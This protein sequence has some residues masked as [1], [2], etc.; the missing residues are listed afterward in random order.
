MTQ[1][2]LEAF[3]Y[4]AALAIARQRKAQAQFDQAVSDYRR[5]AS[6]A[7][8][9]L[10]AWRE[11]GAMLH[12]AGR[13]QQA[14]TVLEAA[15]PISPEDYELNFILGNTLSAL[16]D[17]ANAER[18]YRSA[19]AAQPDSAIAHNNL[20]YMLRLRGDSD[21]A[22]ICFNEAIVL[23]P[24]LTLA[25]C[26]LA[27]LYLSLDRS[28]ETEKTARRAVAL[29][30]GSS[31]AHFLLARALADQNALA[32]ATRLFAEGHSR[33]PR[34]SRFAAHLAGTFYRVGEIE[35]ALWHYR[36]AQE[37][38]PTDAATR[39]N[40]LLM[41]NYRLLDPEA[42]FSEHREWATRIECGAATQQPPAPAI[43]RRPI[44][45]G[46][47]SA[48]LYN[49][50]VG[51]L[52][53]PVLTSHD[54]SEFIVHCYHNNNKTDELTQRLRATGLE[55]RNVAGMSDEALVDQVRADG[56]D[57][58]VDL[59]GHTGGNRLGVFARRAAPVQAT[60]L[61]Y[62]NTTGLSAMDYRITDA[63]AD[64]PGLSDRFHSEALVRLPGTFLCAAP[65]RSEVPVSPLPMS[66]SGHVT[67]GC[68]NNL[69]KLTPEV[70][71][72]WAQLIR[73]VERSVL[74]IKAAPL[75]DPVIRDRWVAQFTAHGV[76]PE[77]LKLT[78]RTGYASHLAA[79]N[80]VDLALDPFP[81]NG[82]A[83]SIEGLWMG[84]PF[85]TLAGDRHVARVGAS[86]LTALDLK[87]LIASDASD[88]LRIAAQ[89]VADIEGLAALRAGLRERMR[90]SGLSDPLRFTR[91]LEAAY[92]SMVSRGQ[93]GQGE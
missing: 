67:F 90:T 53:G 59:A 33:F 6:I 25:H 54:R 79:Y 86:L 78:G 62:P 38:A 77:R 91:G 68:F 92:R 51:Q 57:L 39:S 69:A 88:Y 56:I 41:L 64:P 60:Y 35:Q 52:I 2:D 75:A 7:P 3:R 83:T 85:V 74:F 63:V 10:E 46:Y 34:E 19:V 31:T 24:A 44:R 61:G 45:I 36:V 8:S 4:E 42:V 28:S 26:N 12:G 20:G 49:H 13:L 32:E 9:R 89:V 23:S 30:P 80:E 58:L 15:L 81:Y 65:L 22:I 76:S 50:P 27:D 11:V 37:L 93:R 73:Q 29:D 55:W 71:E 47:V 16:G 14:R 82:T 40:I 70:V 18:Y 43:V 21:G 48:D 84:V 1:A 87:P 66:S 72:L 17:I 5:A